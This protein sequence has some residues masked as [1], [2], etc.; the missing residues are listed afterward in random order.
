MDNWIPSAINCNSIYLTL[1]PLRNRSSWPDK[2]HKDTRVTFLWLIQVEIIRRSFLLSRKQS[3]KIN[4]ILFQL[5]GNRI[6]SNFITS[7]K[8]APHWRSNLNRCLLLAVPGYPDYATNQ[9]DYQDYDYPRGTSRGIGRRPISSPS[10]RGAQRSQVQQRHGVVGLNSFGSSLQRPIS[11]PGTGQAY[12]P[13]DNFAGM[14]GSLSG[15][16]GMTGPLAG[17]MPGGVVSPYS[18][19]LYPAGVGPVGSNAYLPE[20]LDYNGPRGVGLSSVNPTYARRAGGRQ[21]CMSTRF[22]LSFL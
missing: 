6:M 12:Q 21:P 18:G 22:S 19:Q 4:Q 15:V 8:V 10:W 14:P 20:D 7:S 17:L 3:A 11:Y 5:K 13:V 16:G 2:T 9:Y 1:P